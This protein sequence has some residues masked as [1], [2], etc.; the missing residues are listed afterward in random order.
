[1]KIKHNIIKK[2]FLISIFN[3]DFASVL[4]LNSNPKNTAIGDRLFS[5]N[6]NIL[7]NLGVSE[8]NKMGK[9]LLLTFPFYYFI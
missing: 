7:A 1:M 8:N 6:K 5:N 9:F 4:D 2:G 3:I